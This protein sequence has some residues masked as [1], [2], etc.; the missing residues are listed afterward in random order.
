[1]F[2]FFPKR[3][4]SR[5]DRICCSI[6][7]VLGYCW[8]N[9]INILA[10]WL[11]N[12]LKQTGYVYFQNCVSCDALQLDMLV[13][14]SE[15]YAELILFPAPIQAGGVLMHSL[16]MDSAH[17]EG[18]PAGICERRWSPKTWPSQVWKYLLPSEDL[19]EICLILLLLGLPGASVEV[20]TG[21]QQL[22]TSRGIR[23]P[24][25]ELLLGKN[26]VW[27]SCSALMKIKRRFTSVPVGARS[28]QEATCFEAAESSKLSSC[29]GHQRSNVPSAQLGRNSIPWLMLFL[30]NT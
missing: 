29:S 10:F 26:V 5:S 7:I 9:V 28:R 14:T 23:L 13:I 24:A 22:S 11:P 12:S 18:Q 16:C 1:M 3:V 27:K 17:H 6:V 2:S 20:G 30:P 8:S 25:E 15:L 21:C 4:I 19:P